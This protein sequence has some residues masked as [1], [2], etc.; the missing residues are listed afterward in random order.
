MVIGFRVLIRAIHLIAA[1]AWVGGG[2]FYAAALAPALRQAGPAPELMA[3]VGAFFR[4]VVSTSMGV[5]V[6]TGVYLTFDRLTT[7]SL[8]PAYLIVLG[9]KILVVVV[10]MGLAVYQAQESV[11]RLRRPNRHG[12]WWGATP[13]IILALGLL[14][15]VLGALLTTFA[16][17]SGGA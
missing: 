9:L 8:G 3:K 6:L 10:M 12:R 17:L 1:A 5:L 2:I 13:R 16:E 11:I 4:A 14:A 15:F 7:S